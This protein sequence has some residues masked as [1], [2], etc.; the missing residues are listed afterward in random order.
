VLEMANNTVRIFG[1]DL[2]LNGTGLSC[3]DAD[4]QEGFCTLVDVVAMTST[5]K[6]LSSDFGKYFYFY[7]AKDTSSLK[8]R[9]ERMIDVSEWVLSW[10]V[11]RIGEHPVFVGLEDYA[12]AKQSNRVSDIHE[13]GGLIKT[14]LFTAGLPLKTYSPTLIKTVC[15]IKNANPTKRKTKNN[16]D[17]KELSVSRARDIF[18]LD[19]DL[20]LGYDSN[21][22]YGY[23]LADAMLIAYTTLSDLC[24]SRGVKLGNTSSLEC[25]EKYPNGYYRESFAHKE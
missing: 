8:G 9:L 18:S 13:L 11:D 7:K 4:L 1:L 23:D 10:V 3:I 12:F 16:N 25:S 6:V 2:S 24:L 5:K 20:S 21:K 17:M 15:G 22:R 19:F 14:K